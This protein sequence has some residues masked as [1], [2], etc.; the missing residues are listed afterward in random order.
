M[1][2]EHDDTPPDAPTLNDVPSPTGN[3]TV[4]ISGTTEALARLSISGGTAPVMGTAATD[5]RSRST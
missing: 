4:R 1:V 2:I 5:E 3:T